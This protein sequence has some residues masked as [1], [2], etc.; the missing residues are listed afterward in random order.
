MSA[1]LTL[2]IDPNTV[3]NFVKKKAGRVNDVLSMVLTAAWLS[4]AFK[5]GLDRVNFAKSGRGDP[6][7]NRRVRIWQ[8]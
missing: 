4:T 7:K 3:C 5:P 6:I 8:I 2:K 1:G